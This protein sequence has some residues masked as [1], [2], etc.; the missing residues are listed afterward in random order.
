MLCK[1]THGLN[2]TK[3]KEA[4]N[5]REDGS[6]SYTCFVSSSRHIDGSETHIYFEK[7]CSTAFS[8][9]QN[10]DFAWKTDASRLI[11]LNKHMNYLER[12]NNFEQ[13]WVGPK[14]FHHGTVTCYHYA[15]C[16]CGGKYLQKRQKNYFC[17]GKYFFRCL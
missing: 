9:P 6:E 10:L 7:V 12:I 15:W 4:Q 2:I 13:C 14:R 5:I 1:S 11:I 3:F 17:G 8:V 16:F